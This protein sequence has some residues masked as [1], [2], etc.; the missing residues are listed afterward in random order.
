MRA[1][2]PVGLARG[3][4]GVQLREVILSAPAP[5]AVHLDLVGVAVRPDPQPPNPLLEALSGHRAAVVVVRVVAARHVLGSCFR[6]DEHHAF[7]LLSRAPVS[8]R[9]VRPYEGQLGANARPRLGSTVDS[10]LEA[11][12]GFEPA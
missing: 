3:S 10:R 2:N 9:A 12:T 8:N 1:R 7:T 6:V 11:L 4:H 5:T